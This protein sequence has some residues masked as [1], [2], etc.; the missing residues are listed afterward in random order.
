ME[1]C[2]WKSIK[3][4]STAYVKNYSISILTSKNKHALNDTI[5]IQ[6]KPKNSIRKMQMNL[7]MTAFFEHAIQH[8]RNVEKMYTKRNVMIV[9]CLFLD[10]IQTNHQLNFAHFYAL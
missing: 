7:I 2:D 9:K 5:C 10:Q 4:K 6:I 3:I 8:I 1:V